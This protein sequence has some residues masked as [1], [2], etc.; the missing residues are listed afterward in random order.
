[1]YFPGEMVQGVVVVQSKGSMSHN[2]IKLVA[3]G[4]V[5]L[6]NSGKDQGLM[7]KV[8]ADAKAL[9][10]VSIDVA[11]EVRGFFFLHM[12]CVFFLIVRIVLSLFRGNFQMGRQ[13]YLLNSY[14]NPWARLP[15]CVRL[16]T[17]FMSISRIPL[18]LR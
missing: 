15:S 2:G 12:C 10:D 6:L 14:C 7:D 11:G 1:M 3:Q 18:M 4:R 8:A 5:K 9:F 13:S 17:V 16:I